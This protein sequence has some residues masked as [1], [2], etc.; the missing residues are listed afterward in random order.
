M[1]NDGFFGLQ[2]IQKSKITASSAPKFNLFGVL[3]S[4]FTVLQRTKVILIN[5]LFL[6]FS[7][8]KI[9]SNCR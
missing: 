8:G 6:F 1:K 2:S 4:L 7:G 3:E 9:Y 5:I